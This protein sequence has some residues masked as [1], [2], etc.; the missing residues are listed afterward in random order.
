MP[1]RSKG[2]PG[3]TDEKPKVVKKALPD[4]RPPDPE[5]IV[6]GV[7][8]V[9]VSINGKFPLRVSSL[10]HGGNWVFGKGPDGSG[11]YAVPLR[12]CMTLSQA[13]IMLHAEN[14]AEGGEP[15]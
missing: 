6:E 13:A 4:W 11:P 8:L 10:Q 1:R 9:H 15:S 3:I 2:S 7:T 5:D 12:E 14:A